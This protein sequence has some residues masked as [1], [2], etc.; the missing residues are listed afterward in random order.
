MPLTALM[1]RALPTNQF[2]RRVSVLF[3]GTVLA[4]VI[5]V[6]SAPFLTRF[7]KPED[8]GLLAVFVALLSVVS[9]IAALRYEQAIPLPADEREAAALLVLSFLVICVVSALSAVPFILFRHRI[10]AALNTPLLADYLFLIPLG[11]LFSGIYS[12]LN[13]WALRMKAFTPIAKTKVSQSAIAA[14]IQI[15]ASPLGPAALLVGQ[16]VG[17]GSGFLSLGLRTVMPCRDLIRK[18]RVSDLL[19]VA[20]EY[21]KCPIFSTWSA[22]F[23]TAGAQ[24]PSILFAAL[25]S[26]A[27]AGTYMLASRVLSVP[28][29]YLGNSIGNVFFTDAAQAHREG[30]LGA[31]VAAIHGRLAHIGMPPML[32]LMIAG[33]DIFSLVFGPQWRASGEFA[34]WLAPW[35]Y[36]VFV[37]APLTSIVVVLNRQGEG[38]LVQA[39][40]L[41]VR[42]ATIGAGA[43]LGDFAL[44]VMLFALGSAVCWLGNLLWVMH[45][46]G[47]VAFGRHTVSALV[48]ATVLVSPLMAGLALH[49]G[50]APW[51]V[52]MSAAL[53]LVASRYAYLLKNAWT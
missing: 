26:P 19:A 4:Q 13:I 48:W 36:L 33:P 18:V 30:K 23:N 35:L 1:R 45:V 52:S 2:L 37:T 11:A 51:L 9:V 49:L 27:A 42:V 29:Q 24:L 41:A 25:F 31:L 3:G 34:R 40:L 21:K 17:L 5:M 15:A 22:I 39:I 47:A 10:A 8:F 6:L 44:A 53:L 16:V 43:W 20:R 50:P 28:M 32:V 46:C 7:Y 38:M 12:T 14:T